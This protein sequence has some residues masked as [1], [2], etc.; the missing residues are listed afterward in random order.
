PVT[1][2]RVLSMRE[3]ELEIATAFRDSISRLSDP[4]SHRILFGLL[5]GDVPSLLDLKDRPPAYDDVGREVRWGMTLP[6]LHNFEGAMEPSPAP[7]R[8]RM[9]V[10]QE[11]APPWRGESSGRRTRVTL[12]ARIERREPRER[13]A[14]PPPP[15]SPRLTR[16]AY[17]KVFRQLASGKRLRIGR[18]ILTPVAVRGWYHAV[19]ENARGEERLL[20]ID[21]VLEH[22]DGWR[23]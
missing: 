12:P 19:F 14:A 10:E 8:R 22:M 11:L 17:E 23:A 20:S 3:V 9:D 13:R 1:E 4:F 21:D 7:R 15:P 16:S 5:N 2:G 18:E 6:E